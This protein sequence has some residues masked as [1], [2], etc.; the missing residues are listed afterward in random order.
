MALNLASRALLASRV[1]SSSSGSAFELISSFP[2]LVANEESQRI[3]AIAR[4]GLRRAG[5]SLYCVKRTL[6]HGVLSSVLLPSSVELRLRLTISVS[7][8]EAWRSLL[9]QIFSCVRRAR[10]ELRIV[11]RRA[12]SPSFFSIFIWS[13]LFIAQMFLRLCRASL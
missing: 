11:G 4:S 7:A 8:S 12:V 9:H 6:L 1:P 3:A 13:F 10:I 2:R 5:Q